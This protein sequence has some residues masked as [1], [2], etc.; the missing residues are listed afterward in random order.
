ME[1]KIRVNVQGALLKGKAPEI[2]QRNLD[3][4]MTRAT[5]LL[6]VEVKKK[7]PQGVAGARGGLMGSIQSEVQG[8]GTPIIKGI[9]ASKSPYAEVVESGR[10]AGAKMPPG[11][12]LSSGVR[13]MEKGQK[14]RKGEVIYSRLSD[15]SRV[16]Y[17]VVAAGGLVEWIQLKFGVDL[18]T[19]IR[20]EY[21]VR[22]SIAK[23]GIKGVHMFQNAFKE[24]IGKIED[25]FNKAGFDIAHELGE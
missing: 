8:K 3:R 4:A 12:V 24:N 15:R 19:A 20:L 17:S 14:R 2:V 5:N 13:V 21:V 25:I 9:V 1:L 11:A 16:A 23:K 22:K 10:R 7:T 6:L 18:Q